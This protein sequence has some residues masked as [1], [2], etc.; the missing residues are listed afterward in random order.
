MISAIQAA[1]NVGLGSLAEAFNN[2]GV[3][4]ARGG[5]WHASTV[6]NLLARAVR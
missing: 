4:T 1:G 3:R 6:R 2:R 5:R